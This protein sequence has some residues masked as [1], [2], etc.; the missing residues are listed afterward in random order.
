MASEK[1]RLEVFFSVSSAETFKLLQLLLAPETPESK[2]LAEASEVLKVKFSPQSSEIVRRNMFYKRNQGPDKTESSFTAEL[3]RL[4]QYCN[5]SNLK[6][7]LRDR[8]VCRLHDEHLQ[9]RL[10][11]EK[12]LTFN[13]A[14]EEAL[15]SELV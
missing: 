13:V 15:A 1:H 2:S 6:G 9:N 3:R 14:Q 8:L 7:M 4:T 10:F 11:A 12:Q 5:L